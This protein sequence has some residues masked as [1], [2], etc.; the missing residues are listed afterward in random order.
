M[1]S[2][3][4]GVL[5]PFDDLD[6]NLGKAAWPYLQAPA[7]RT[8]ARAIQ[9]AGQKMTITSAY[10]TIAQQQIIYNHYLNGRRCGIQ[11]AAEPPNSNH[12]SGLAVDTPFYNFW[13]QY[14]PRHSWRWFG[15][16]DLVHFEYVG[17][18]RRRINSLAVQAFQRL[19]NRYNPN[20]LIKE[21][22]KWGPQ[23]RRRLENSPVG[24]FDIPFGEFRTLRLSKP[25]MQ[26]EDVRQVQNALFNAGFEIEIDGFYGKGTTAVVKQF[27][28]QKGLTAD[29]IVGPNTRR[30]LEL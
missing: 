27:Q 9:A 26:G 6:V 18:G 10:R 20:D 11:L 7:K 3:V 4:P 24:G 28:K 16:R 14:L 25:Y 17:F 8:L 12:Q 1:N 22:G 21:D 19:W 5:V 30:A 13:R 2:L 29:G 23:T 15:A